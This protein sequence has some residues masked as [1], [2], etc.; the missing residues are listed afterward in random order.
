MLDDLAITELSEFLQIAREK[1]LEEQSYHM[2]LAMLPKM[3]KFVPFSEFKKII[4]GNNIDWRDT[5]DI[6]AE[7]KEL[8]KGEDINV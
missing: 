8:H 6:I 1:E 5:D 7:I 4:T 2:W 3:I